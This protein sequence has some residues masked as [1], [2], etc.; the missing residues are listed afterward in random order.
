MSNPG[1]PAKPLGLFGDELSAW[2]VALAA[3]VAGALLTAALAIATQTFFKQQLRQRFELLASERYSRIVER[4]EEQELR[5]DG[6]RRF[7]TYSSE[8]TPYAFDGYARPL[9]H[10]T[11]AYSWAP[12]VASGQRTAFEQR[13]SALLGQP[14]QIRDLDAQGRLQPAAM[15]DHYYPILYTQA[16]SHEAQP[17]GFD[18]GGQA[19]RAAPL[20]RAQARGSMAVSAPLD[21]INVQP[22]YTRGLLMV[23]PV[24][25]DEAPAKGLPRGYVM[26]LL[27]LH[28][29][30]AESLPTV[31]DDNLVVRILDLS[32]EGGHEVLFDSG[33]PPARMGLASSHLL[34]LADHHYQLDI[35]PSQ[36]FL[37]ANQSSAVPVV[38]LLG[39]LLSVLLALLL[40][41]LF[42]QRQRALGLVAR[43]TAELR[44][45]EQSLRETHNQLRSVLDAATQ[46]AIIATSLRGVIGTFNAGAERML[47]YSASEALG[48]LRLEDLVLADELHQRAHALSQR[49]GREVGAGQAMFAETAQE[50]GAQPADWTLVRKDGSHLLANMLVTAVLDEQ[51]LWVGYLAICIDVTERRRVH[52]ALAARDRL[53]EK[54][55]AEVPGGIYQYR[56]DADG[57]SCFPYASQGLHEIYEVDLAVLREDAT[58]VFE[59]IHPDDLERVRRS[60]RYSAEHLTPWR[61]EY[62]VCLPQAGLR[63]VRG[64]ATP[65]I[66]EHGSTL[67]HGYLTDISDLKRVEEEL[68][69]LS[70]TDALTGIYNRRYF[71]ERLRNELDRAQREGLDLAVIMLDIDHFKR[72][73]DQ[74]GHAVGDHVLRSLCQRIAHRLRRT[75][76]FC[77]LGGEEFMVLCPGS[78][79]EQARVL[80][81]ELWRGVRSVPVEGVGRVTASFGVAGWRAGEG[82]DALL[83][84]ADAGV[85]AAK[86]GGR[87]RVEGELLS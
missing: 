35:R 25:G 14:Y 58:A 50:G 22:T 6:L 68:R 15:R 39:G 31:A 54:L 24:F 70:V 27:S 46:V 78:S 49:F 73:N 13:S 44:V 55:S 62:R 30:I 9:L 82:A 3:L 79:A 65:E 2:G 80:A 23:A 86:Q 20:A 33:G 26:A 60:V 42:S 45:S 76:V 87:D 74:F 71:Q 12:R 61:E 72:I 7:I 11:Q 34:H 69:A 4:F 64:E 10:R 84:R 81:Q 43:R 56:L 28:Q 29:L 52:E 57:H 32:S 53:L 19:P 21:M 85:Y 17:Y 66:G 36:G 67:W 37:L 16:A 8:V 41:S 59:R 40:Y 63:W 77:R 38:A 18:M 51:G 5:L 48:Q 1:V 83:L 75:D 47:G